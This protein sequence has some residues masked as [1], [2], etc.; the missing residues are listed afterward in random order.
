MNLRPLVPQLGGEFI[1]TMFYVLKDKWKDSS[2]ENGV[3]L[4]GAKGAISY[5]EVSHYFAKS[6]FNRDTINPAGN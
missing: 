6:N 2:S 3:H 1:K 4:S 5:A